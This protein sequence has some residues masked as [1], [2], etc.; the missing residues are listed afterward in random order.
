MDY[1]KTIERHVP[2]PTSW[3]ENQLD[4]ERTLDEKYRIKNMEACLDNHPSIINGMR[5]QIVE[6]LHQVQYEF[7]KSKQVFYAAVSVLDA[8]LRKEPESFDPVFLQLLG[9]VCF[10]I[11]VK[12]EEGYTHPFA[13]DI[14]LLTG[15]SGTTEEE[16]N[17]V[18]DVILELE[19]HVLNQLDFDLI[20]PSCMGFL[21][22]FFM[23]VMHERATVYHDMASFFLDLT[24]L[25]VR[26]NK[27]TPSE[28]AAASIY[29]LRL[30][31]GEK[32]WCSDFERKTKV[33][34]K[35]MYGC[36]LNIVR[37]I[38][39]Q[40]RE[41]SH[42]YQHFDT[43]KKSYV[44]RRSLWRAS[45]LLKLPVPE[46]VHR[47]VAERSV[48]EQFSV[49]S[50]E[51]MSTDTEDMEY[52]D[53][54]PP[55]TDC[56]PEGAEEENKESECTQSKLSRR[57]DHMDAFSQHSAARLRREV[58]MSRNGV[59]SPE[60]ASSRSF[61]HDGSRSSTRY[62][63]N[64]RHKEDMNAHYAPLRQ[65]P[66][67]NHSRRTSEPYARGEHMKGDEEAKSCPTRP[68]AAGG[69]GLLGALSSSGSRSVT[70]PRFN[71]VGLENEKGNPS[72]GRKSNPRAMNRSRKKN[73]PSTLTVVKS[74]P[75][76]NATTLSGH[77]DRF[78]TP[79]PI[80]SAHSGLQMAEYSTPCASTPQDIAREEDIIFS[81]SASASREEELSAYAYTPATIE[82]PSADEE[83]RAY[84]AEQFSVAPGDLVF[85]KRRARSE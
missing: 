78:C 40:G 64:K 37:L 55:R 9:A 24:T 51:G 22:Q 46:P 68:C 4:Q 1:L 57:P 75:T 84:F 17:R 6:W 45:K 80:S 54:A 2:S 72:S 62:G 16:R 5:Y 73:K 53:S 60:I 7:Q 81:A 63:G 61:I 20:L 34:Y 36:A 10:W 15:V 65:K 59:E 79:S 33:S 26:L 8:Y 11:A 38:M 21:D 69:R 71:N 77:E 28:K 19:C 49:A 44:A 39:R 27:Y 47:W 43:E 14:L 70:S 23:M 56:D 42:I 13:G 74:C 3:M 25:D 82:L 18:H 29:T 67:K 31:V 48:D 41:P 35:R 85:P 83:E 50:S 30:L 58:H 76:Y 66:Q 32:S 12:N 52:R